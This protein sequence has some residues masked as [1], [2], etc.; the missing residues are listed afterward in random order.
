MPVAFPPATHAV[1][2]AAFAVVALRVGMAHAD[3]VIAAP[4]DTTNAS[5]PVPADTL[6][7]TTAVPPPAPPRE[8]RGLA[9]DIVRAG[10]NYVSDLGYVLSSPARM[11]VRDAVIVTGIAGATAVLYANDQEIL[12]AF[13]RSRGERYYELAIKPGRAIEPIGFMGNTNVFYIGGLVIGKAFHIDPLARITLEILESHSISGG[14]R[15]VAKIAV[16]R[17][18]P[19]KDLGPYHFNPGHGT[20]FPSGHASV[21]FELATIL[22]HHAHS[23]PVTIGLYTL[24]TSA[25]LQR[26]DSKTHWPSDILASALSGA[27]I[28]KAVVNRHDQRRARERPVLGFEPLPGGGA[29]VVVLSLR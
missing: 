16:G 7:D 22:A 26:I 15:N 21:Q 17:A 28:A 27:F 6:A 20:S 5:P 25:A 11:H 18:Q 2:F 4:P 23:L 9:H 19:Y 3:P 13:Q 24:A 8:H 14:I 29:L 12:D 10:R 1:L